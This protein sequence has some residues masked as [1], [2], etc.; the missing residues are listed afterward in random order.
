MKIKNLKFAHAF[1]LIEILVVISIMS[2]LSGILLYSTNNAREKGKDARRK[3]DLKAVS[4]ALV[5][6]YA[7]NHHYPPTVLVNGS[8]LDYVSSTNPTGWIPNLETYL[9]K[10]PKDPLQA[11][12]LNLLAG[13][14]KQQ[15]VH[16]TQFLASLMGSQAQKP[17]GQVA[18]ATSDPAVDIGGT[19]ASATSITI[20]H[21][22]GSGTNRILIVNLAAPSSVVTGVTYGGAS[23]TKLGTSPN[24]GHTS[25]IWYLKNP[26][27]GTTNVVIGF[28]VLAAGNAAVSSWSGVDQ[29]TPFGT[30]ATAWGNTGA[31]VAGT[32]TV[33]VTSAPGETVI[34]STILGTVVTATVGAGQTQL[35]NFA[36]V[37]SNADKILHSYEAGAATVTMSWNYAGHPTYQQTWGI[38]AV[39]LKPTA[40]PNL[41][42]TDFHLTNAAG[43]TKTSFAPGEAIYPSVTIQN[44]GTSAATGSGG[45]FYISIYSNSP[46]AVANGTS[47]DV[48]VWAKE[49][50]SI[51]AGVSKTYSITQN[52]ANWTNDSSNTSNWSKASAASYTARAFVDS[53]DYVSEV[54]ETST[55]NQTTSAYTVSTLPTPTVT[56]S[57]Q[58]GVTSTG[59]TL[60]GSTNPNGYSATGYFRYSTTSPG[61]CNDT[62]GTRTPASG[63]IA[64]GSG[65]SNITYS[66]TIAGLTASTTYY[67]CALASNANGTGFG[68]ILSFTTPL[69]LPPSTCTDPAATNNGGPLP[70]TYPPATTSTACNDIL[71][72]VYCL[73]TS[74]NQR[75]FALWA[76]LENTNDPELF[77]KLDAKCKNTDFAAGSIYEGLG[78]PTGSSFNYC[79]KSPQ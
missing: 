18:G 30:V 56:T 42:I 38:V 20:P 69:P 61:T 27:S 14:I 4:S 65:T 74:A 10:F 22:V 64:L 73:R 37:N 25:S 44:T 76:K 13:L 54:D 71:T 24:G 50:G 9:N 35:A 46:A 41:T 55:N 60:N 19:G 7:D 33:N 62:F 53:F 66:Q 52:S 57:A 1:T 31:N 68:S 36:S 39:S 67:F 6:Y 78:Q 34:D 15:A 28:S 16:T 43:T 32:A 3:D 79:I 23:L 5:A 77:D 47:S 26:T 17:Q 45:F 70:C 12:I 48:N 2:V 11:G 63:G 40:R 8:S 49:T 51:A 29:T 59:A 21:T 58:T 75:V 72:N